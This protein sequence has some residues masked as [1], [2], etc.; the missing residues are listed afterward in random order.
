MEPGKLK[1]RENPDHTWVPSPPD[2]SLHGSG[3][4]FYYRSVLIMT[5]RV[6]LIIR[7]REP[8]DWLSL[9]FPA[10]HQEEVPKF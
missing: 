6:S 10:L 2:D 4:P 8:G 7:D 3:Q 1:V 5:Q 9:G